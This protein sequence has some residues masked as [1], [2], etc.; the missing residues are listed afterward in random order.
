MTERDN[1]HVTYK[2]HIHINKKTKLINGKKK[3]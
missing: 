1:N 2:E 3:T